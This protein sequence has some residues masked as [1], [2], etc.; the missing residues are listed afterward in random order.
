MEQALS[1]S[2]IRHKGFIM[3]TYVKIENNIVTKLIESEAEF[4]NTFVD[5]SP[6]T[7]LQSDI[8][9]I[10]DTYDSTAETF[11]E[12]KPYASWV[13]NDGKGWKPPV[14]HPTGHENMYKWDEESTA[15][16]VV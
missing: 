9:A 1:L 11:I 13:R 10:G 16:V 7:W 3:A 12:P 4:F 14:N 6:G 15:W 2:L 5:T 8:A